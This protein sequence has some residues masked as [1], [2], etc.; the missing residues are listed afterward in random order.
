[1]KCV[2]AAVV[3]PFLLAS[4]AQPLQQIVDEHRSQQMKDVYGNGPV[5]QGAADG[6]GTSSAEVHAVALT[7][8]APHAD[9][10]AHE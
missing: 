7:E 4:C 6:I 10:A 3:I 1:M 9:P 2:M 5:T 8:T